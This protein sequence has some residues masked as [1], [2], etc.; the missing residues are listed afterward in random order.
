MITEQ[1]QA[2]IEEL[3]EL[4]ASVQRDL[5]DLQTEMQ[6]YPSGSAGGQALWLTK[7]FL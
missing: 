2:R 6:R 4:I 5:S 7:G 1:E 3:E